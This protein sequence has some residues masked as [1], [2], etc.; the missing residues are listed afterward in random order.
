[1]LVVTR[2]A[3]RPLVNGALY[4]RRNKL[5]GVASGSASKPP[6]GTRDHAGLGI[7]I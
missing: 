4:A 2:K 6:A 5:Q 7:L 1:L 3:R